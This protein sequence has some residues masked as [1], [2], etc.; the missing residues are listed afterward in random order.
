MTVKPQIDKDR[1]G[2]ATRRGFGKQVALIAA[3]PLLASA[4]VTAAQE[5][6]EAKPDAEKAPSPARAL[7]EL[8]R[9]HYG[10]HLNEEQWK[11]VLKRVESIHRAADKVKAIKLKNS[12]EPAF[13]FRADRP[14]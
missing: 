5:K 2:R 3:T 7:T 11:E 4:G 14:A 6:Q 9:L 13:A 10:K 12:D 1:D 8:L